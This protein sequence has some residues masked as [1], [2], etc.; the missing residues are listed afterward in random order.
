MGTFMGTRSAIY[1]SIDGVAGEEGLCPRHVSRRGRLVFA[2]SCQR[3]ALVDFPV[4]D[5]QG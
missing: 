3:W 2:G 5:N 1:R 4:F